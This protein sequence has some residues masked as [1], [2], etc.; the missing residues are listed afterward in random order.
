MG[1][2]MDYVK[3]KNVNVIYLQETQS[4]VENEVD[5]VLWWRGTYSKPW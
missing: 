5:W 2:L 3:E 4:D 1:V